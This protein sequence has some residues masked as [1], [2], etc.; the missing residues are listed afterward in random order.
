MPKTTEQARHMGTPLTSKSARA[1][2]AVTAITAS[3]ATLA[4]IGVS[5]PA[6][7]ILYGPSLAALFGTL[8]DVVPQV[9]ISPDV[10]TLYS[11]SNNKVSD[12]GGCAL[13]LHPQTATTISLL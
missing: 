5:N 8:V 9:V 4:A 6:T 13:T 2:A 3:P 1:Q 11:G 7:E 12:H 10:G